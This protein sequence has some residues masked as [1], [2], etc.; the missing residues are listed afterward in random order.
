MAV[1]LRPE[2]PYELGQMRVLGMLGPSIPGR[3]PAYERAAR[4]APVMSRLRS[5][6]RVANGNVHVQFGHVHRPAQTLAVSVVRRRGCGGSWCGVPG[7][8]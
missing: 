6:P 8:G 2:R 3:I 1:D 5:P 7:R 4:I